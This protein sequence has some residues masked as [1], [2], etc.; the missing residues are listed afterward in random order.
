MRVCV[1]KNTT[2]TKMWETTGSG[3]KIDCGIPGWL[4]SLVVW[5]KK[6]WSNV[7]KGVTIIIEKTNRQVGEADVYEGHLASGLHN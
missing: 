6:C 1:F 2:L 3:L 5:R 4:A 7:R